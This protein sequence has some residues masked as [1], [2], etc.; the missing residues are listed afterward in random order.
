MSE[1]RNAVAKADEYLNRVNDM[2]LLVEQ[3]DVEDDADLALYEAVQEMQLAISE[4]QEVKGY[5]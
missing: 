4:W 5:I 2:L 1:L 3:A